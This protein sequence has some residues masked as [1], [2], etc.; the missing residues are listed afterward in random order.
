MQQLTIDSLDGE[1][2]STANDIWEEIQNKSYGRNPHEVRKKF[3]SM[4]RDVSLWLWL[5]LKKQIGELS[6]KYAS[7]RLIYFGTDE[8]FEERFGKE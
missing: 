4:T 2:Y 5:F 7:D 3:L 6:F 1:L 8:E